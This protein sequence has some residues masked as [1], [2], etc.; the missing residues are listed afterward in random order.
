MK[1]LLLKILKS[2]HQI[3]AS[4]KLVDAICIYG[5]ELDGTID[6]TLDTTP[7]WAL[8]LFDD[9]DL[10]VQDV[11]SLVQP[12]ANAQA[13]SQSHIIID[14]V[15]EVTLHQEYVDVQIEANILSENGQGKLTGEWFICAQ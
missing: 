6:L 15:L 4:L 9:A 14:D 8:D 12:M 5:G 11:D 1:L 7:N 2:Y 13:P 10:Q 3:L